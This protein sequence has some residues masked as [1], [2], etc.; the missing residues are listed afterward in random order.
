VTVP[1]R[2]EIEQ[3]TER[4][5]LVRRAFDAPPELVFDAHT[6]PGMLKRWYG[7][8][9]W[10]MT[11]CDIDLRQGGSFRY[12]TR[13]PGGREIGQFGVFREVSRPNRLI[14]SE[15][16]EDWDPG[17]VIVTARFAP[18]GAGTLLTVTTLFPS[19]EVRDRLIAHGMTDGMEPS[20][21]RLDALLADYQTR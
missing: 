10:E 3:P 17:E 20:Y 5:V 13:Q 2:V 9:G 12:V 18:E 8:P 21:R 6:L 1:R 4:E 19:R 11:V 16:W 7:P 14:H 15:R